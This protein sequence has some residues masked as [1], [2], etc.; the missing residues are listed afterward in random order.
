MNFQAGGE[1]DGQGHS[2]SN[3]GRS[4]PLMW[5]DAPAAPWMESMGFFSLAA[6][7]RMTIGITR[8]AIQNLALPTALDCQRS[9]C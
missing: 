3:S 7:V 1:S 5:T 2:I 9:R 4:V 8:D 6:I